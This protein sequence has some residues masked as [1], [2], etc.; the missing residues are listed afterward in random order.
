MYSLIGVCVWMY[1]DKAMSKS[2][3]D[4]VF[5]SLFT[6]TKIQWVCYKFGTANL[7]ESNICNKQAL[8]IKI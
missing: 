7:L 4:F 6:G 8:S 2:G 3:E 5:E 1:A